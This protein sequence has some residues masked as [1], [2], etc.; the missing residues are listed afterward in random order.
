MEIIPIKDLQ[1]LANIIANEGNISLKNQLS[2]WVTA[3][4]GN[5][6]H[7]SLSS[8]SGLAHYSSVK[9]QILSWVSNITTPKPEFVYIPD[10]PMEM[11]EQSEE[12]QLPKIE[13]NAVQIETTNAVDVFTETTDGE[14]VGSGNT[15]PE[16][17]TEESNQTENKEETVKPK[18]TRKKKED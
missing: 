6:D 15:Q 11:V 13:E 2:A 14:G 12:I 8:L 17:A 4:A 7:V 5:P 9:E 18:K 16:I 1:N 3:K 10:T